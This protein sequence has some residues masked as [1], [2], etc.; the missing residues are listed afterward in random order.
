MIRGAAF[1]CLLEARRAGER[2]R[3][4]TALLRLAASTFAVIGMYAVVLAFTM[5]EG[6]VLRALSAVPFLVA[7]GFAA[8]EWRT[9]RRAEAPEREMGRAC[10]AGLLGKRGASRAAASDDAEPREEREGSPRGTADARDASSSLEA[11]RAASR[12]L[13]DIDGFI[14]ALY[15]A[16]ATAGGASEVLRPMLAAGVRFDATGCGWWPRDLAGARRGD[17]ALAAA[18]TAVPLRFL[19]RSRTVHVISDVAVIISTCDVDASSVASVAVNAIQL[20]RCPSGWLLR[21]FLSREGILPVS[22]RTADPRPLSARK[23]VA[24]RAKAPV[25]H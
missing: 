22:E 25:G 19:E 8:L 18:C 3:A 12:D 10:P 21:E 14:R 13:L 6:T 5:T 15:A 2:L 1:S 17:D 11:E 4:R 23:R 9:R 7:M 16:L 20:E 24:Q